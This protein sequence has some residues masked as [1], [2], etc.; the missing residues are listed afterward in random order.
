MLSKHKDADIL[1]FILE[2]FGFKVFRTD[3]LHFNPAVFKKLLSI[4]DSK[5]IPVMVLDGP[6]GPHKK[7]N[8]GSLFLSKKF[9]LPINVI[10]IKCDKYWQLSSWDKHIIP[11][12]LTTI[13]SKI[14]TYKTIPQDYKLSRKSLM[15]LKTF[16][17]QEEAE[18][19]K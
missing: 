15:E 1:A 12:P 3:S 9:Q 8:Y 11:K 17:D 5:Y 6:I 14:V 4:T 16:I 7:I 2:K 19:S 10:L 13:H 18:F